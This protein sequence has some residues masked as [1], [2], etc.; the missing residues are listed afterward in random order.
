MKSQKNN[1]IYKKTNSQKKKKKKR[2]ENKNFSEL[3]S[4]RTQ[5]MSVSDNVSV[6][7]YQELKQCQ[8]QKV[9]VPDNIMIWLMSESDHVTA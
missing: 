1:E 8:L 9:S 3:E 4:L 2:N 6:R 7:Q 5:S